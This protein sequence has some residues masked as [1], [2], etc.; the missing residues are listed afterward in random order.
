MLKFLN[1]I[2]HYY[3][4]FKVLLLIITVGVSRMVNWKKVRH[5]NGKRRCEFWTH[6]TRVTRSP[7]RGLSGVYIYALFS[8][9]VGDK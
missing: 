2:S 3:T 8:Y 5:V 4:I 9:G 7:Q 6:N 1:P